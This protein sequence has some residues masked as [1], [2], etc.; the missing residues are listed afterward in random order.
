VCVDGRWLDEALTPLEF[1]MLAYLARHA[2]TICRREAILTALYP[3][4]AIEAND[5]RIDTL[6]RRLREALGEDGRKPRHLITHR[7]VGIRL[8]QGQV[9]E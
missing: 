2:G 7:R 6:L 9:V 8:A 1:S 5:E 3:D 4:E